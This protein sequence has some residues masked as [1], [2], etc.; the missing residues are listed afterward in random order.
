MLKRNNMGTV[1]LKRVLTYRSFLKFG[2]YTDYRVETLIGLGRQREIVSAYY[3]LNSIDFI[4]EIL[5][6]MG[7]TEEFRIVKPGKD[8]DMYE[9][10]LNTAR[11]SFRRYSRH[12]TNDAKF[13]MGKAT[14]YNNGADARKNQGH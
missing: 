9:K 10:F 6:E 11:Y 13:K 8:V 3:K 14:K 7:I 1:V 4:P 5:T 12:G 2:K